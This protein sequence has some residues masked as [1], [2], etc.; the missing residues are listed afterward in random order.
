MLKRGVLPSYLSVPGLFGAQYFSLNPA[1]W[2]LLPFEPAPELAA[3]LI[4]PVWA[5]MM[6]RASSGALYLLSLV[7]YEY[8]VILNQAF[9]I[10]SEAFLFSRHGKPRAR[11]DEPFL[12]HQISLTIPSEN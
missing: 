2:E 11:A 1:R 7:R 8:T 3:I 9:T 12:F 4:Q 10:R 5:V 6:G